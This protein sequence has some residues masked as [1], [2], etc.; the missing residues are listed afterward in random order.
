MQKDFDRIFSVLKTYENFE[1]YMLNH[2]NTVNEGLLKNHINLWISQFDATE[3]EFMASIT[4]N[5]LEQRFLSKENEI[6]FIKGLFNNPTLLN[7]D[8]MPFPL[9]IQRNGNSQN[10]LV[11]H[12]TLFMNEL[13]HSYSQDSVIYLDDFIFS[14]GRV[15]SDLSNWI[16]LQDKSYNIFVVVIGYHTNIWS[17]K[18]Q[19]HAKI[20]QNNQ[21]KKIQS[22]LSFLKCY[23]WEN[24]LFKKNESDILWPMEKFFKNPN[25]YSHIDPKFNYRDGFLATPQSFF[26]N[27]DDRVKFENICL[28]YGFKIIQRCQNPNNTTRPL[29]NYRF[30]YGFGG[31]VFTY[32][33]CPNNTPL[34]FWWG[35]SDPH[36]PMYNQWHPLMPRRTYGQAC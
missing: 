19:L 2:D 21:A 32:K 27:N 17:V 12:Y 33:N 10:R 31:L 1:Q 26:K 15:F 20:F 22:T 7:N 23:E 14:G 9:N 18:N 24:R 30:G 13:N 35:S 25:Y 5:L 8:S 11:Q 28:K 3:Q 34:L 29:G 16:P 36:N 4:A 6:N